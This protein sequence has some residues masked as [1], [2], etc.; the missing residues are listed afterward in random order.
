MR[1]QKRPPVRASSGHSPHVQVCPAEVL[2]CPDGLRLRRL[3]DRPARHRCRPAAPSAAPG[4]PGAL[5]AQLPAAAWQSRVGPASW[6]TAGRHPRHR[7]RRTPAA[8]HRWHLPPNRQAAGRRQPRRQRVRE[9]E[10][11][12]VREREREQA[13][14][15]QGQGSRRQRAGP[16]KRQRLGTGSAPRDQSWCRGQPVAAGSA[17]KT[18]ASEPIDVE[19]QVAAVTSG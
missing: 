5:A 13:G 4:R 15:R 12:R 14:K 16:G 9:R 18:L 3:A 10:R 19:N 1:Q 8:G 7:D 17:A 2:S 11:Q 6:P